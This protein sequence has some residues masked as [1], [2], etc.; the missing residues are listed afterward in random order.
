MV[1]GV[2][3][4]ANA[5]TQAEAI[6]L[7]IVALDTAQAGAPVAQTAGAATGLFSKYPAD[8]PS[9]LPK[10][11]TNLAAWNKAQVAEGAEI[12]MQEI[13]DI[14]GIGDEI[15]GGIG[16]AGDMFEAPEMVD[17]FAHL[18]PFADICGR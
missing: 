2:F 11:A 15:G 10:N 3:N 13:G 9:A 12:E 16:G 4:E 7:D 14:G 6:G 8:W 1:R 18:D 5:A 17:S